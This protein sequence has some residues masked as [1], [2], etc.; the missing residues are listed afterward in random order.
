MIN[1]KGLSQ[2]TFFMV[3]LIVALVFGLLVTVFQ[4]DAIAKGKDVFFGQLDS[5][6]DCDNDR[7][8]NLKD[9][10][11]CISSKGYN[12]K[13]LAG[14]PKDTSE[15][16]AEYDKKTCTKF[17]VGID[18]PVVNCKG[19][20]EEKCKE[21]EDGTF[22]TRCEEIQEVAKAVEKPG[23][24]EACNCDLSV[25]S[26]EAFGVKRVGDNDV[27]GDNVLADLTK[28]LELDMKSSEFD[29]YKAGGY[30][31]IKSFNTPY[32]LVGFFDVK[33]VNGND[34]FNQYIKLK[35]KFS[36][37]NTGEPTSVGFTTGI[38]LCNKFKLDCQPHKLYT[39]SDGGSEVDLAVSQMGTD[40]KKEFEGFVTLSKNDDMCD[41]PGNRECY[42]KLVVDNK[43]ALA[44][45]N[46]KEKN[47]IAGFNVFLRNQFYDFK[48]KFDAFRT[49][50]IGINDDGDA[51][52]ENKIIESVCNG[53]I[54]DTNDEDYFACG[55]PSN[56]DEDEFPSEKDPFPKENGCLVVAYEDDPTYDGCAYVGVKD[57]FVISHND[58][59]LIN[60]LKTELK[61]T[62]DDDDVENAFAYSWKAT[63]EGSLL[64]SEGFWNLCNNKNNGK[65]LVVDD[66]IFRCQDKTWLIGEK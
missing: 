19:N 52:P 41:G 26:L 50:Q 9:Q 36:I 24:G 17:F 13:D 30:N 63:P 35:L 20:N 18:E 2:M 46:G 45:L 51:D 8:I 39:D 61:R 15:E 54:G 29:A 42:L 65:I 53:Y 6:D 44:E 48:T 1:K 58:Y 4:G 27:V 64:C 47:N 38:E 43:E 22:K 7:A 34:L 60:K 49:V 25:V 62:T 32:Q 3:V 16:E 40:E 37:K 57:D 66:K 10:C 23:K 11:P 12:N 59:T 33:N 31:P 55:T 28:G 14:C 5:I 21:F 56:C